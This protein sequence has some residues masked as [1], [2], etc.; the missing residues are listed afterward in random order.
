MKTVSVNLREVTGSTEVTFSISGT[1]KAEIAFILI[2]MSKD[3]WKT[4]Q[5]QHWDFFVVAKLFLLFPQIVQMCQ[6]IKSHFLV[7]FVRQ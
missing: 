6:Q 2:F 4:S 3:F 1:N 5:G 7:R